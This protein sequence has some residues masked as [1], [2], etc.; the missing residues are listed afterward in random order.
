MYNVGDVVMLKYNTFKQGEGKDIIVKKHPFVI[1]DI[2]DNVISVASTSSKTNKVSD[3]YPYNVPVI[4]YEKAN[5]KYPTHIKTD[6]TGIIDVTNIYKYIGTLS[7]NDKRKMLYN[8]NK[9]PD[10]KKIIMEDLS[11]FKFLKG[12]K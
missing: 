1:T 6:H 10:N 3:K 7:I 12:I 11:L 9:C 5:F 8:I 4:D 2:N